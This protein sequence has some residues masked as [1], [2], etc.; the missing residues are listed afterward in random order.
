[1]HLYFFKDFEVENEEN[2][3]VKTKSFD[4]KLINE[5]IDQ[6]T[7]SYDSYTDDDNLEIIIQKDC[8]FSEIYI[9][10]VILKI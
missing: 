10:F 5:L 3:I 9:L 7:N 8:K 6:N 2:L 4:P 1:M